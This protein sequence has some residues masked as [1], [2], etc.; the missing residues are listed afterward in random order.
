MTQ[1]IT[2]YRAVTVTDK[3]KEAE[4]LRT[5]ARSNEAAALRYAREAAIAE[6]DVKWQSVVAEKDALIAKLL[7]EQGKG[8]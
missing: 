4:R 5:L 1:A 8:E 2:A 6:N 7:A 3:F